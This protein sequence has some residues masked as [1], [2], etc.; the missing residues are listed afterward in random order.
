MNQQT[1]SL[2]RSAVEL[3][4]PRRRLD[5]ADGAPTSQAYARRNL[6][7]AKVGSGGQLTRTFDE[8]ELGSGT[9][10]TPQRR[11]NAFLK[12]ACLLTSATV[13]L[14]LANPH[15]TRAQTY[16]EMFSGLQL[17]F[18]AKLL[19]WGDEVRRSAA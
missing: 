15:P 9:T 5:G 3:P 1:S 12:K 11:T 4:T 2:R 7:L 13:A 16:Q 17:E 18:C 10:S 6:P 8:P 14:A 19:T